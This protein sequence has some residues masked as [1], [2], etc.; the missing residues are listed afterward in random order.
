VQKINILM[1]D[2]IE[3][4]RELLRGAVI[5]CI[6]DDKIP[7]IPQ[8]FHA[9]SGKDVLDIIE[10]KHIN[11]VYLDIDLPDTSG[12]EILKSIKGRFNLVVVVMVSGENSSQNVLNAIKTGASGFI[13]K[14]FN[15]GRISES[16]LN[17]IKQ[18]AKR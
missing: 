16:L 13:V 4:V 10:L 6:D 2:D 11:L 7:L 14:P 1:V 5:S 3:F 18:R 12:L 17:Y 8:F 15:S 9:S